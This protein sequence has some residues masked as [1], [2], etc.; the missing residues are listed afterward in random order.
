MAAAPYPAY[1]N[2]PTATPRLPLPAV[3]Q[4]LCWPPLKSANRSGN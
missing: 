4:R 1:Q 3:S 2:E